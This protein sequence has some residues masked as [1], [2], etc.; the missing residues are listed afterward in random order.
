MPSFDIVSEIDLHEVANAVDQ[1]NREL[2]NR[3]DFR[4][5]DARFELSDEVVVLTA[6]EAY[7][8]AQMQEILRHKLARRNVDARAL[9]EIGTEA[10]GKIKR[11]R[12]RLRRGVGGDTARAIVKLI[13]S[14]KLKVQTAITGEKLRVTGKKR[15]DLQ[16]VIA[17]VREAEL[18]LPLQFDN[19]RD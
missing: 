19:F 14:S 7:Q 3:F 13:K 1:S 15:D 18:D 12:L 2:A 4:G 6:P 17:M 16:Q 5:V 9:E 10:D 11:Q 8:L